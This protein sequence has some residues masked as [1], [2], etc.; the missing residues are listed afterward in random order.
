[1]LPI[2]K[3]IPFLL[4]LSA[5]NTFSQNSNTGGIDFVAGKLIE[6][7][8]TNKREKIFAQTDKWFYIAGEE[9][10]F[11]AYCLN[12]VS[13]KISHLGKR[14]YV[15]L[16]NDKDSVISQLL[17]NNQ[18]LKLEGNIL[19]S[20]YL[21]EG[22][23]WLRAYTESMLR[24]TNSIFV[25][26]VYIFSSGAGANAPLHTAT[27]N[28]NAADTGRPE[29]L[30]F[31]EGGSL[32]SGTN[33][34]VGFRCTDKKGVPIEISGTVQDP[35]DTV[36]ATFKT[37]MPGFGKFDFPVWKAR[38]YTVHIK[39]NNKD[40]AYP[41]P[42]ANP[43]ASQLSLTSQNDES[44]RVLVSLGDSLYKKN[45]QT[46]LLA[47]NRDSLCF[48]AMGNDMYEV[49]IQ[50]NVLPEGKTNLLLFNDKQ[51]L[52]SER[53]IYVD[54]SSIKV[55]ISP[56][57]NKYDAREKVNLNIAIAD[58]N[59]HPLLTRFSLS[60]TN[61]AL[62]KNPAGFNII[63][64][65]INDNI[66]L[67]ENNSG[68][69]YTREQ[70]D[71]LMLTQRKQF[72]NGDYD[73]VLPGNLTADNPDNNDLTTLRGKILDQK[74]QP[75]K[76]RVVTAFSNAQ[77]NIVVLNDTTNAQG[78]FQIKL[79]NL[80]DS[81]IITLQVMNL[82]GIQTKDKIV[83]SKFNFPYFNTPARLKKRFSTSDEQTLKHFKTFELDSAIYAHGKGWLKP[84]TVT[85]GKT[86]GFTD[87]RRVSSS[88]VIVP[89]D[90]L[91]NGGPKAI[92]NA[93]F[94]SG[95]VNL[96]QGLMVIGS[97]VSNFY[98]TAT[99]EPLLVVDGIAIDQDALFAQWDNTAN[100]SPIAQYIEQNVNGDI[101]FIEI[102]KGGESANYGLRGGNG[103]IIINT[104][105]KRKNEPTEGIAM[106][107][108]YFRGYH[109]PA[110]FVFPDYDKKEIKKS[111]DPDQ[112]S[113][114]YWNGNI[115]TDNNGKASVNFFTADTKTSYTV[116][117]EGVTAN[118][119]LVY[120]QS[121][122]NK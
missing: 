32:I 66:E 75:L 42:V 106:L 87:S 96:R 52:V 95:A 29:L 79:P 18:Q 105:T 20:P 9:I 2:R 57:K 61:D 19:L 37:T 101:D 24:D 114:I 50:K 54:R 82:K 70:W 84:V 51:Q 122:I 111:P 23:Y 8:R 120:A 94:A 103:V 97:G 36:V 91:G 53:A 45:R 28:S 22:Y 118:G 112:R 77:N 48:A 47:I 121:K 98:V 85:A 34:V 25:Q 40:F 104:S 26:P 59:N 88:S 71:I 72:P 116:A 15:D 31:P 119:T 16:V 21:N 113:I 108:I 64:Q 89:H 74:N 46:F 14:V 78:G 100:S 6:N 62:A 55:N 83:V 10:R 65:L 107:K 11:S 67:P 3:I 43:Y 86:K 41:L 13:H 92:T 39:W 81:T 80:K 33:S 35:L 44:F 99:A 76:D 60:A 110:P 63:E 1:M 27:A 73:M 30:L 117:M 38:K 49:F 109:E 58:S 17:L 5:V 115:V 4:L 93:L 102:L 69:H 90:Q 12:A 7:I 56:D 68:N